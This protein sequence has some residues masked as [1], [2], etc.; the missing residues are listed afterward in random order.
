VLTAYFDCFSGVSGDMILGALVDAGLDLADLQSEIDHLGIG[1]QLRASSVDRCGI[2]STYVQVSI[3]GQPMTPARE[4]HLHTGTTT[5]SHDDDQEHHHHGH[6]HHEHHEHGDGNHQHTHL[7]DIL[8]IIDAS[9]LEAEVKETA[10]RVFRR[11]TEAEAEVHGANVDDVGLH[12]VGSLD[13]IVDITGA[14]A[15]LHRLGVTQVLSSPLHV[16]TGTVVCA[17]GRYPVPVPG[18][19]ALCRDVPLVQ[20][21][22]PSELVTPTGAALITTL[23]TS[24]GP[25]PAMTVVGT[26][27]GAGGRNPEA[28][29]NVLRMR[30]GR[31]TATE[32][33]SADGFE[34]S[35]CVL[36]E[37]NV[38]DMSP[39]VFGYLFERLLEA[40]AR[41]VY[42]TPVLMKKNRPG[43]LLSVLV[44]PGQTE[45][46]A[47]IILAETTSLGV[48]YHPVDRRMLPRTTVSVT[49]PYGDVQ[50][51]MA[52]L[53]GGQ[54]AAPE[55]ED[56]AHLARSKNVPL[57]TIYDAAL[58]AAREIKSR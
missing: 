46:L 56:C 57:Q 12:E 19:L 40:G 45:T 28:T 22:I 18:V 11:L 9:T 5:A 3:E 49:T 6:E 54:R 33:S 48:R 14:I 52:H 58:V 2:Q 13:A 34:G 25:A 1:A 31:A 37:A 30:L 27:Y 8:A 47:E 7:G 44:D 4:Q 10:S 38:D 32:Q 50:V 53:P 35:R 21:D 41:D 20:T 51:K 42:V 43:H 26:G 29:P 17:H 23:A 16:G 55:Y 36:L 24:F 15:G 39:E